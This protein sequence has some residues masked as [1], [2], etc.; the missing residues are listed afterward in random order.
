MAIVTTPLGFQKPDG[1]ELVRGGD[2]AIAHNA[3]T[4]Q[5]LHAEVR[6]QIANLLNAAG[7]TGDVLQLN[8]TAVAAAVSTGAQTIATINTAI[9]QA[10]TTDGPTKTA[11]NTAYGPATQASAAPLRA[12]F[13]AGSSA[14]KFSQFG[15][16]QH[17]D[18]TLYTY[19]NLLNF[20]ASAP[21]PVARTAPNKGV[22][23]VAH[24]YN[25]F[26]LAKTALD[27]NMANGNHLWYDWRWNFP[28]NT[29]DGIN[30]F[31]YDPSRHP[32]QGFYKGDD[33]NVL[34]WQCYWMAE[35]GVTAVAL[36]ES[37]GFVSAGW[38]SPSNR[39]HWLYQLFTNVP[40]FRSL[41]YLLPLTYTGTPAQ[42]E[43]QN[44]DVVATY[45]NYTNGYTYTENGKTYAV[46]T[47]FEMEAIRGIYDN[48]NGQVNTA[49]YLKGLATKFKNIG[50]D[51][52]MILARNSG[53]FT[54]APDPTLKPAGVIIAESGYEAQYG[55]TASYSNSYTNYANNVVFPTSKSTVLNVVTSAET[56]YPHPSAWTL[57]GSTPAAFRKVLQR[58]VDAVV[59]NKQRR[60]VTIYNVSEWAE[61]GPGLI[62]QKRDGFGYLDAIRAVAV[63]P[64][65]VTDVERLTLDGMKN[66]KDQSF[67]KKTGVTVGANTTTDVDVSGPTEYS[68]QDSLADYCLTA[69]LGYT[70]TA[71]TLPLS[72]LVSPNSFGDSRL[73]VRVYN[74]NTGSVTGVSVNL[75]VRRIYP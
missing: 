37:E 48:Y 58:A 38:S 21:A 42:L 29:G 50:Y 71:P 9:T 64:L 27:Q 67:W 57:N 65:P 33:P 59:K 17:E 45:A 51:G 40:N 10:V 62:P 2:N 34:G 23:I 1:N 36:T 30:T 22:D 20:G 11:L 3:Q 32:I 56:Q 43:A 24:W 47:V 52:V 55:T 31:G 15:A 41:K 49:V 5:N 73:W 6:A 46:V 4:A 68:W 13:A 53:L 39:Q 16:P 14:D 54:V 7:F 60:I 61:G 18:N 70:G 75:E 66:R 12:A 28:T 74:P 63:Q 35:A 25:D 8:D 19:P 69:T 44:D 72:V 26:G